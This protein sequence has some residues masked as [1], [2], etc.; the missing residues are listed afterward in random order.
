MNRSL[1]VL[2]VALAGCAAD[3]RSLTT[4]SSAHVASTTRPA[5]A[6]ASMRIANLP[7]PGHPELVAV[8]RDIV[9][10]VASIDPSVAASAGLFDDAVRVPSYEAGAVA[11]MVARIDRD[12]AALRALP[13]QGYPVDEQIDYRWV[14]ANAENARH[15]LVEE[16][17]FEHRPS[18]WLE[19]LSNTLI[20]FVSYAPE[21][22][23]LVRRTLA[24]VPPMVSEMRVAVK[25]NTRRDVATAATI[26]DAIVAMAKETSS[27]EGRA[28]VEALEGYASYLKTLHP[29]ADFEVVGAASYAWRYEHVALLPWTPEELRKESEEALAKV[30]GEIAELAPK[31]GPAPEPTAE[32]RE[33]A[34]GLTRES[35]LGMYDGIEVALREATL[36]GGWVS[37]PDAVGAVR[38][39][40][41]PDAMVPLTGDGG[42]MNPPPT[43][44][45]TNLSYWN[46]EHFNAGWSQ[47]ERLKTVT[48]AEGFRENGMGPYASHEGFPG[49]HLQLSIARLNKDPLR[50]VLPDPVMNEGWALY[51]EQVML[52]HGAFGDSARAKSAVLRSLRHRIARVVVDVNVETGAWDLQRA[53]DF[54]E[55]A[56]P[57]KGE[58]DED[59]QRAFQWPTQLVDYYAGCLE[60]V[61]LREDVKKKLGDRFDERAFHDALLAEGS[62]PVALVRAK[63][64][65]E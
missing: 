44:V 23:E 14:L 17:L 55:H 28:A 31:L 20:A 5:G 46:V 36:K 2:V 53:A 18:Q 10:V 43:Y 19:P 57:G 61:R 29:E 25:R 8:A 1:A 38:A 63:I 11:T 41:T 24:L 33:R 49:H 48:R 56:A 59:I 62:V 52:E 45:A 30:E 60:I 7:I 35:L 47:D 32:Q 65:G 37:I 4:P 26:T 54:R 42:S 40:E 27:P 64:L 51:V 3:Q 16:R 58:I 50:S 39:R 21:R 12:L 6:T 13:W 22:P 15:Q 9:D 34:R